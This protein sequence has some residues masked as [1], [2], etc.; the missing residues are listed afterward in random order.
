MNTET[1]VEPELVMDRRR[2]LFSLYVDFPAAVRARW[3]TRQISRLTEDQWKVTTEMWNLDSLTTSEPIR[4]MITRDVAEADVLVIAMSSLD[5][6]EPEL[7]RW[8]DSLTAGKTNRPV[9]RLFIGLLGDGRGQAV[10]LDWTVEQFLR[11]ARQMGRDFIW[12]WMDRDAMADDDWLTDSVEALLTRRQP[13]RD[14]NFLP[15]AALGN[16][17][18]LPSGC[19]NTASAQRA[20]SLVSPWPA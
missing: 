14:V 10:E 16:I 18:S 1:L 2:H 11:C 13:G 3:A 17:L 9:P 8:L 7:V 15:E 5:W 19:G 12:H 20:I 4:K 6:R